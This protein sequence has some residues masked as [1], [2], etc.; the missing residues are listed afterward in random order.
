MRRGRL[1]SQS[2][3]CGGTSSPP[4]PLTSS[5]AGTS[6]LVAGTPCAPPSR[7]RY[8]RASTLVPLR[9]ARPAP[10]ARAHAVGAWAT[11]S[12]KT[13]GLRALKYMQELV[14]DQVTVRI[15]NIGEWR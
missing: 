4:H 14:T 1:L 3:L 9:P 10:F 13:T 7:L 6:C 5:L 2:F 12:V 8:A 11:S 15:G